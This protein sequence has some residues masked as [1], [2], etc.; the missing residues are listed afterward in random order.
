MKISVALCTHNGAQHIQAQLDSIAAQVRLPDE[1]IVYDDCSSDATL[2]IVRA[3]APH[4]PFPIHL[5]VNEERLGITKNFEQAIAFCRGDI[6]AFCDQDDVWHTEKLKRAEA[7]FVSR[8]EVGVV[9]TDAEIVDERLRPLGESL[10]QAIKF[11]K[12]QRRRFEKNKGI[13]AMLK[14]SP[15]L[16]MTMAFRSEFKDSIL[17][18]P[19]A[20]PHD[21]WTGLIIA[22]LARVALINAPLVK[23]RQH[24][25][26]RLGINRTRIKLRTHFSKTSRGDSALLQAALDL[27]RM[28]YERLRERHYGQADEKSLALIDAKATHLFA[29]VN[30]PQSRA[31]RLPVVIREMVTRRYFRYSDGLYSF[32]KDLLR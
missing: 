27:H 18:I 19:P 2:E 28:A 24:S 31:L 9:F 7:V 26:Q 1:L 6:V 17:P 25:Q 10:W 13:E 11:G 15:A 22:A 16:G 4:A 32:A 20:A 30:M 14:R 23:Y 5:Q 29:R 8:P 21:M 3:F 12:A